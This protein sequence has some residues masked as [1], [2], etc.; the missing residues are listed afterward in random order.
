DQQDEMASVRSEMRAELDNTIVG[1]GS[2]GPFTKEMTKGIALLAVLGA[3]VGAVVAL[4]FA[5]IPMGGLDWWARGLVV[6]GAGA[7]AGGTSGL[8]LG[9][10]WGARGRADSLAAQR[11]VP[12]AATAD[13]DRARPLMLSRGLIRLDL[14]DRG[15]LPVEVLDTDEDRDPGVARDLSRNLRA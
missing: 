5:V 14:V 4:P 11:G 9:G 1:P 6:A 13:A 15:R 2:V 8:V 10:A 12:A 7:L 3:L